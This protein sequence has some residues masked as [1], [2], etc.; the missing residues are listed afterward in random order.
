MRERA[1]AIKLLCM[2]AAT[3]YNYQTFS[4]SLAE[5]EL[6]DWLERGPHPGEMAPD[7]TLDDLDGH[8]IRLSD[9]RGRPVV[10]EFGSYTCPIFCD[11]VPAM[12]QLA[13][14]HPEVVF[15]VIAVRE[16]HPGEITGPHT[17]LARKRQA[18]RRLAIEEGIRRQ[19]LIDDLEGS[20]HQAYGGAWNA[21]YVIDREGRIAFRRAW[22]HPDEVA[23]TLTA[24]ANGQ[25][26]PEG[27]SVQMAQ[28]PGRG[29][30]GLRLLERGGR[31]ALLDFYRTAPPPVRTGLRESPSQAVRAVIEGEEQ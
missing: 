11:R 27:E 22:N 1:D 13:T 24:L 2:T 25:P 7:F 8:R 28:L 16:A 31:Q 19:V 4:Y 6:T 12:E 20:V 26:S 29:A 15:L 17:S 21:V 9:L 30:I 23:Q 14:R 18:A 10:L 3:S 5:L